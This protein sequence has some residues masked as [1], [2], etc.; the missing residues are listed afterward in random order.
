MD[1][2]VVGSGDLERELLRLRAENARLLRL[3]GMTGQQAR[4]PA[5]AQSG[6][7]LEPPGVVTAA[8]TPSEK[9]RFFRTLF[10]AR[11][12]VYAVRWENSRSG[13]S[14]WMPA[15]AGGWSKGASRPYLRLS[16]EVVAEHL[17]GRQHIG[18]YPLLPGD[19]CRWLA[20]DFDGPAAMLDALAYLKAARAVGVPAVL[21]VSRSG[22]GAH[23]SIFFSGP[24]SEAAART[25][26]MG[27]LREAIAVRGRMDLRTY[28]RLFPS[29]DV[30]PASGGIGNLIAAPLQGRSRKDGAT[31]FLDLGTLEP[32]EDQWA[33]LSSVHR[34]SPAEVA[35]L[36]QRVCAVKVGG[37]VERLAAAT[38]T[39]TRPEP[40]PI[41]TVALGA[42][43]AVTS[44]DLTPATLATIKHAASMSNPLFAE[45]QRRRLSTW[46]VPR[47]LFSYEEP[48]DGT[49]VVP[50]GLA[51]R[52]VSVVEESGRR[53]ESPTTGW[54]GP[55][56]LSSWR[57]RRGAIKR[58]RSAPLPTMSSACW[59][60]SPERA[61]R[62]WD[63]R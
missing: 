16:D 62:S 7:F 43:C 36:A 5:A 38:S 44:A 41:V 2:V 49:L 12:D 4:V 48:L 17:S 8:S 24:V 27:L 40:S 13:K 21:E 34:L 28:D 32:H 45:R 10:A 6:L 18:L 60:P 14:G 61:R 29:Q 39:K 23:A 1:V 58:L 47:F 59:W 15:I 31:V 11:E 9:V 33:Y 20:A 25:L 3:L 22:V 55:S 19:M 54:P 51:D 52:V 37:A 42:G 53:V 30:L 50:R 63:V 26:G 56:G 57:Q 46:N 35:K